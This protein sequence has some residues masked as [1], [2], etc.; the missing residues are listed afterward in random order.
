ML[1][2]QQLLKLNLSQHQERSWL[3][4]PYSTIEPIKQKLSSSYQSENDVVDLFG[5]NQCSEHVQQT[6]ATALLNL[7]KQKCQYW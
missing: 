2:S 3:L 6:D 1:L 4:F 5:L 7:G